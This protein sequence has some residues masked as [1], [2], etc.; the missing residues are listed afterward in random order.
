VFALHLPGVERGDMPSV[1]THQQVMSKAGD[2]ITGAAAL[3]VGNTPTS[4]VL[5]AIAPAIDM[6]VDLVRLHH[7]PGRVDVLKHGGR[8]LTI[9]ERPD[10][11]ARMFP[12][13][14][15]K[16]RCVAAQ[17]LLDAARTM[18]VT[19]EAGTDLTADVTDTHS[20]VEYGFAEAPGRYDVWPGGFLATFPRPGTTNGRIV[21]DVG[22]M[23]FHFNKY[24]ETPVTITVENSYMTKVVGNGLDAKLIRDYL[25][26]WNDPE[27]YATSH[28]GW[29]LNE[30]AQ[31]NALQFYD[32]DSTSVQDG[33]AFA[34][35]FM[36]STGP[37]PHVKRFVPGHF[38][39]PMRGCTVKLDDL[40]VVENGTVVHEEL[41]FRPDAE[42]VPVGGGH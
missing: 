25:E 35:N 1:A 23:I 38:D 21:L 30:R 32:K 14:D 18:R 4:A 17:G 42:L 15:L 29:G 31:W 3:Y 6:V 10:A 37:T 22:D 2:E 39:I 20:L 11:L 8:Y 27:C 9:A 28:M 40:T 16:R 24:I 13:E 34:G 41:R 26:V 36:W 7:A 5:A 12:T 33:R 19:S